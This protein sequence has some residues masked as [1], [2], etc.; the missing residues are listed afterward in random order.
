MI[1]AS[2]FDFPVWVSEW[3]GASP[4]HVHH[5]LVGI[6]CVGLLFASI[7]LVTMLITRWGDR[8]PSSQSLLFSLLVHLSCAFGLVSI[9]PPEPT[10][11]RK[12]EEPVIIQELRIEG[13]E[14]AESSDKGNTPVWEQLPEVSTRE[15]ARMDQSPLEF[16]PLQIDRTRPDEQTL[17]DLKIPDT[18]KLPDEPVAR[19]QLQEQAD[20]GMRTEAAIPLKVNDETAESRPD[21]HVPSLSS[22]RREITRNGLQEDSPERQPNRGAVDSVMPMVESPRRLTSI[23]A[24]VDPRASLRR[25]AEQLQVTRRRGAVPSVLPVDTLGTM[26]DE[27]TK[28]TATGA[29]APPTFTR[30]PTRVP[31]SQD[32]GTL[33]RLRPEQTP[34]DPLVAINPSVSLHTGI[35]TRSPVMGPKPNLVR[36]NFETVRSRNTSEIPATYRL[37]NLARRQEV[38]R[39]YGGTEASERAVESSLRWLMLH[40]HANGY[41]DGDGFTQHCPPNDRCEGISGRVT[42]DEEGVD[43]QRAGIHAD[44]GLTA[45][46]VLAF[47]G[48]GYTHEEG[49]YADA[50]QRALVW[51]VRQQRGDGFLGGSATRYARM[52]CHGMATYAI[53]EAYAMQSDLTNDTRLREPLERAIAY[54]IDAQN[55]RDGGWRYIKGQQ[56]DMSMFGWQLMA[57]K[58]AELGGIPISDETR[59]RMIRFL[60]DRSRGTRHGLAAYRIPLDPTDS[61]LPI[62]PSMTSEALFCKQMLG[63]SRTNP[64][65]MEAV[66]YLLRHLPKRSEWNEYYWYYGTLAMYQYGG[67]PWRQWNESLR[68]ILVDEQRQSGHA[69]GSWNPKAPWGLY[70]GRVYS[71]AV[72]TLCLEVYYRFL[73]LY[74]MGGQ[75]SEE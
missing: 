33:E 64:A 35:D 46:A 32:K 38:A 19:P 59:D 7:H 2:A 48:A 21:V 31:L 37:R 55:P 18:A 8:A 16:E 42:I 28:D 10:I 67:E 40:Q 69:A 60:K 71:T 12:Q 70:G 1:L 17:P 34:R 54:I 74:Q 73:P 22:M 52:Y 62:T 53:A 3:L 30:L 68:D 29:A 6:L 57:L 58:S 14:T 27:Q 63:I 44:T 9:S 26:A 65:S 75:Y 5:F 41:W 56:S 47:L 20:P 45:L 4:E 25:E 61:P 23:E 39:R 36:P 13:D 72:A 24:P 49:Q 11:P 50:V 51:L 66:E 43:R 15:L